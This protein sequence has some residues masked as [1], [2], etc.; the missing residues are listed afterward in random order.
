MSRNSKILLVVAGALGLCLVACV[1]IAVVGRIVFATINRTD[2]LE[3]HRSQ[4]EAIQVPALSDIPSAAPV[5]F[6]LPGDYRQDMNFHVLG[7]SIVLANQTS[8][9]G[10]IYL[11]KTAFGPG[12]SQAEMESRLR[13]HAGQRS[14][15]MN[16]TVQ[17]KVVGQKM[18]KV[19]G[20]EVAFTVS[21][22]T[23]SANQPYRQISGTFNS[24]D[25][26]I[27]VVVAGQSSTWDEAALETFVASIR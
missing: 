27:L 24:I 12:S 18:F 21:E 4:V 17:L 1:A 25:G 14:T 10:H 15:F 9:Q 7:T 22:G 6:T 16:E 23:N 5:E 20:Q 26:V 2:R 11:M 13:E 19:Q 8:G 3:V